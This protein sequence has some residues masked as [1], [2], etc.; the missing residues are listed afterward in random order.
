[1]ILNSRLNLSSMQQT[2]R[3]TA[4]HHTAFTEAVK[5]FHTFVRDAAFTLGLYTSYQGET[6]LNWQP[7]VLSPKCLSFLCIQKWKYHS[8]DRSRAL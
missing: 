8:D 6:V 2:L 4:L 5:H 3:T 7:R 1:M